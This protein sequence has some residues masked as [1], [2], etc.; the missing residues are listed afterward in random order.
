[1]LV[2]DDARGLEEEGE[3]VAIGDAI[4]EEGGNGRRDYGMKI[5]KYYR[6]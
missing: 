4:V 6:V 1:M 2:I 3:P 5:Y